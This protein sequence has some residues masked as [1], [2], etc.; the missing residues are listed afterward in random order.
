VEAEGEV[1]RVAR[2]VLSR[3]NPGSQVHARTPTPPLPLV[4][5]LTCCQGSVLG[6]AQL[7]GTPDPSNCGPRRNL[8]V[9]FLILLRIGLTSEA[10]QILHNGA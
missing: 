10:S 9:G 8:N 6:D 7:S 5:Y 3:G 2:P 1:S 4:I